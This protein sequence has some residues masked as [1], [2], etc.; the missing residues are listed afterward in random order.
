MEDRISLC[1]TETAIWCQ[2]SVFETNWIGQEVNWTSP[3]IDRLISESENGEL[4][5][6]GGVYPLSSAV[7]IS[8][9]FSVAATQS[10]NSCVLAHRHRRHRRYLPHRNC[11]GGCSHLGHAPLE[12]VTSTAC[13]EVFRV[14]F[15]SLTIFLRCCYL[16]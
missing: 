11:V 7:R 3:R 8:T 2:E 5:V 12:N 9:L 14:R 13:R 16:R 15:V 6:P 1:L 4:A 10:G